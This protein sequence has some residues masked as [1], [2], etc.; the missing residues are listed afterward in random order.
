MKFTKAL[1]VLLAVLTIVGCRKDIDGIPT[2]TI[3]QP[4]VP[5]L[6]E[7]DLSGQVVDE[8][9]FPI[10]NARLQFSNFSETSDENGYFKFES[11]DI[12]EDGFL[13]TIEKDGYFKGYKFVFPSKSNKTYIK[14]M[15][16]EKGEAENFNAS[17]GGTITTEGANLTFKAN[18]I[19]NEDSGLAYNGDVQAYFHWY[20]PESVS[21]AMSMPG[22]L[23][24][25]SKENEIVT[26]A[27]YGMVAVELYGSNGEELNLAPNTTAS[28]S[29]QAPTGDNPGVIPTWSLNEE[30]GYWI[31]EGEATLLDGSYVA[32]LSHFSFW[33]CDDPFT[34]V[35]LDG[36]IQTADGL[37]VA[38]SLIIIKI[39]GTSM[40]GSGFT[41]G[42]GEFSGLMPKDRF[43]EIFIYDE[44]GD[45]VYTGP[46]GEFSEDAS[47]PPIFVTSNNEITTI[48]GQVLCNGTALSAGYVKIFY[49]E[50]NFTLVELEDDGS[51]STSR[52]LCELVG[53]TVSLY[54]INTD[55]GTTSEEIIIDS[56]GASGINVGVVDACTLQADEWIT[57]NID[58]E[59]KETAYEYIHGSY[60][61]NGLNFGIPEAMFFRLEDATS[62]LNQPQFILISDYWAIDNI[63][64]LGEDC[65]EFE[66]NFTKFDRFTG[67]YL[68]G[69]YA[70]KLLDSNG[71]EFQVNGD[72]RVQLDEY[73]PVA[74]IYGR[75]WEDINQDGI[76]DGNEP[77]I[78]SLNLYAHF[79][80]TNSKRVVIDPGGNFSTYV[81]AD[82]DFYL[83]YT[84]TN[85]EIITLQNIGS[86]DLD[87]D[88]NADGL[89]ESFQLEEGEELNNFGLGI[90][91]QQSLECNTIPQN[92]FISICDFSAVPLGMNVTNGTPPYDYEWNTGETT[93]TIQALNEGDYSVTITDANGAQCE[94]EF[95]IYSYPAQ[96][97]E[98]DVNNPRCGNSNGSIT[99]TNDFNFQYV[100]WFDQ[101]IQA[102]E[103]N[104]LTEGVYAYEAFDADGCYTS[105]SI[106]LVNQ[107]TYLGNQVFI[108][109][110]IG[111]LNQF[112]AGDSP[113]DSIRVN[114]LDGESLEVL[115]TALSDITG[116]Y[117]FTGAYE[118]DFVMEFIIPD[119]Y[120]FIENLNGLE[121]ENNSDVMPLDTNPLIGRTE[122]FTVEC[123]DFILYIDCGIRE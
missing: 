114:L 47:I 1:V 76:Q 102:F 121:D 26:M 65:N 41:N 59:A 21:T 84:M 108:D 85:N 27:T 89:T 117:Q 42:D 8:S 17:T 73:T 51:F 75:M 122:V 78:S 82:V 37:P 20:N 118:G 110:P 109:S 106:T 119:G 64:C 91:Y 13:T 113:K 70:G 123:G 94:G 60:G 28:L 4:A 97:V 19:I 16:V 14:V 107:E 58:G 69:T 90:I 87:N 104:D 74:K 46:L 92:G 68:E 55:L 23:R 11:I 80:P 100:Y 120:E 50:E 53:S 66:I 52:F 77:G 39:S 93:E 116:N 62:G 5:F 111:S 72:F 86:D 48:E 54:A 33:N 38:N 98:Y 31:E 30:N 32:E 15:M 25:I 95:Q 103:L 40:C 45:L 71:N 2:E 34:L 7:T 83:E 56:L 9:G 43:L 81:E 79:S 12:N 3:I 88:F 57:I 6:Q 61:V 10:E 29:M 24:G 112:D 101:N 44:C 67:G 22:D 35:Q 63:S 49:E 96:E 99:I 115:A 18:T 105:G 36:I